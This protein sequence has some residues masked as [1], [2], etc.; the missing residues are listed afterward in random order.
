[1][2]RNEVDPH[3]EEVARAA[4]E[5]RRTLVFSRRK[6]AV[7]FAGFVCLWLVGVFARQV[8][9]AA[10]AADQ[11]EAMKARNAAVQ[12]EIKSLQTELQ[13]IQQPGFVD[14]TARGYM[15]GSPNEIP[16]SIDPGA[17]PLAADAPGSMG[18][19][20]VVPEPADSPLDAWLRA[21]FGSAP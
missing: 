6:V 20:P 5:G 2:R 7:A 9:E 3:A 1:M 12:R 21:L 4:I 15:L 17:P 14:S 19:K 8:G 10:A 13:L 11:A 18:I 16:F